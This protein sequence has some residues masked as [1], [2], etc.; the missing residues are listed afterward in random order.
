MILHHPTEGIN[1]MNDDTQSNGAMCAT[2]HWSVRFWRALGFYSTYN[3][4][5]FE[6]RMNVPEGGD[7]I[8]TETT[9]LVSWGDRLRILFSGKCELSTY[10][11][12]AM[13]VVAVETRSEFRVL[14]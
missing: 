8:T 7:M 12:T 13:P 5:L 9:L 6:W 3:E 10:I 2:P 14:P 11:K 4:E 1:K